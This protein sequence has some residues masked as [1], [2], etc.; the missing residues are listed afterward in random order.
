MLVEK[1]IKKSRWL[2]WSSLITSV[3]RSGLHVNLTEIDTNAI[4]NYYI[5]EHRLY[6]MNAKQFYIHL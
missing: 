5:G 3:K 4:G 6:K 1:G 2:Q